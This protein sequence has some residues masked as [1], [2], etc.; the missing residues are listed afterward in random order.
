MLALTGCASSFLLFPPEPPAPN[1][2]KRELVAGSTGAIEVVVASGAPGTE[3]AAFV[4][5]FYG[6]GQVANDA[7]VY[8][9]EAFRGLAVELWGVNYPGYGASEGK[10]T[11]CGVASSAREVYAA[12]A[13]RA[14]GRP[15][16]VAGTSLGSAAALHVAAHDK[17][18]GVVLHNPPPLR[19]LILLRYGWWNLWLFALPIALGIPSELDSIANAKRSKV[20]AIFVSSTEDGVVPVKYQRRIF[21]AYA[22]PFEVLDLRGASH[23]G[24]VPAWARKK[25]LATIVSWVPAI[26]VLGMYRH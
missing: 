7:V 22:G 12:L 14:N 15:I 26:D 23:N 21:K 4:L 2:A 19:Q 3:P 6:N 11:L 16:I 8:E 24:P 17:V 25:M 10:A 20:P 5:R 1:G 18:A 13:K 9:A